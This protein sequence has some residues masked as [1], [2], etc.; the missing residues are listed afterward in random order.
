MKMLYNAVSGKRPVGKSKRS[1]FVAVK[2]KG[3]EKIDK[4]GEALHRRPRPD[5][6]LLRHIGRRR[7]KRRR[8]G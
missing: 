2:L 8:R 7:R 1:W 5:I 3:L 4:G 6:W